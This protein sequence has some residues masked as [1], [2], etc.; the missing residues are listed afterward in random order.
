MDFPY[1][2]LSVANNTR[3]MYGSIEDVYGEI[4]ELYNIS[5]EHN[6]DIG[7]SLFTQCAFFANYEML[8]EP[9]YQ[10]RIKEYSFCKTFSTPA[11]PSMQ[12][13]PATLIEDFMIIEEEMNKCV[14]KEKK[15]VSK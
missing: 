6:F 10:Q 2:A 15:D 4:I 13:T 3:K 9:K 14:A 8:L 5:N 7:E 1:R 12:E 11:Y